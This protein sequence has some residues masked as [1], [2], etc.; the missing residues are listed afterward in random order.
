MFIIYK[1]AES[2]SVWSRVSS[3][4]PPS[5][6]S[7]WHNSVCSTAA[8]SRQTASCSQKPP[9]PP[10]G[11]PGFRLAHQGPRKPRPTL[12][13][14]PPLTRM[15]REP[16]EYPQVQ[17]QLD[18]RLGTKTGTRCR[19]SSP[20]RPEE[21]YHILWFCLTLSCISLSMVSSPVMWFVRS[22]LGSS[23]NVSHGTW[24]RTTRA[25]TP[26]APSTH[27]GKTDRWLDRW[28][29]W[30]VSTGTMGD[31]EA[32]LLQWPNCITITLSRSTGPKKKSGAAVEWWNKH[33]AQHKLANR[34]LFLSKFYLF[35]LTLFGKKSKQTSQAKQKGT[36]SQFVSPREQELKIHWE[37]IQWNENRHLRCNQGISCRCPGEENWGSKEGGRGRWAGE[38]GVRVDRDTW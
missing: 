35:F 17:T 19:P 26:T 21:P 22:G 23:S 20:F 6:P 30:W 7:T 8:G 11:P 14:S 12:A 33:F 15:A 2:S 16:A 38:P 29:V 18:L 9:R 1:P 36:G 28:A 24:T 27:P 37:V 32:V 3:W 5:S 25:A 31:C 34:V 4:S 10:S 13:G